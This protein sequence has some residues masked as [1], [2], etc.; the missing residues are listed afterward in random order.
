MA[1]KELHTVRVF[2]IVEAAKALG[3]SALTLKKWIKESLVPP[4]ILTCAAY[5]Y[6]HYSEGELR[7]I[8]KQLLKHEDEYNYLHTTHD[9]TIDSMWQAME[10]YRKENV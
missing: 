5:G 9:S 3:K 4:P 7:L 10:A 8:A 6:K 2:T 1:D